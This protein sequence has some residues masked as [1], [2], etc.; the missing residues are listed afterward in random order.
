MKTLFIYTFLGN[1]P[2]GQ[3]RRRIFTID[4]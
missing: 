4:G 3:T 1:L 2:T